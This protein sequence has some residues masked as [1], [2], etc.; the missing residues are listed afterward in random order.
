MEK[1]I[2]ID[3]KKFR[4]KSLNNGEMKDV[5]RAS[6]KTYQTAGQAPVIKTD[7]FTVLEMGVQKSLV[8][9]VLDMNGVRALDIKTA[10]IL[11]D[12]VA[13]LSPLDSLGAAPEK[14]KE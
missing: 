9:P 5:L 8:S 11:E 2:E 12:A 6:T 7:M 14:L 3:G 1:E 4:I 10:K 13:E